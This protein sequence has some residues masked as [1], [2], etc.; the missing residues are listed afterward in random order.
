[1]AIVRRAQ[2]RGRRWHA[3]IGVGAVAALALVASSGTSASADDR[4]IR[5]F[6]GSTSTEPWVQVDH[7]MPGDATSADVILEN[8][9]SKS[10]N[11]TLAA[12]HVTDHENG[13]LE[14]ETSSGD[15][16]CAGNG[17]EASAAFRVSLVRDPDG[18]GRSVLWSGPVSTLGDERDLGRLAAGESMPLRMEVSLPAATG[19]ET[20]TDGL[21]VS[22]AWS[23]QTDAPEDD[24]RDE[25]GGDDADGDNE[26]DDGGRDGDDAVLG[27]DAQDRDGTGDRSTVTQDVD[28]AGVEAEA[29][30]SDLPDTGAAFDVWLLAFGATALSSGGLL[31]LIGRRSH[32]GSRV[33]RKAVEI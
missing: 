4:V 2:P 16:T 8:A 20:M 11:I 30:G 7:F 3:R 13:C 5:F 6:D 17:G 14:P 18:A 32:G 21:S 15:L 29:S 31:M 1:V 25:D 26:G 23:A 27:T 10:A 24:V 28:I 19:N 33:R 12:S 9:S 22:L